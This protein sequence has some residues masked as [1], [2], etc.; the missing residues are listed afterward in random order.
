MNRRTF[1]ISPGAAGVG[2]LLST[3][4]SGSA[5]EL[6]AAERFS[7]NAGQRSLNFPLPKGGSDSMYSCRLASSLLKNRYSGQE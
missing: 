1:L 7:W 6:N 4:A 5:A 2:A 3:S